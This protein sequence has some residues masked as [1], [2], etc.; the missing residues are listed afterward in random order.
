MLLQDARAAGLTRAKLR[1]G[2]WRRAGPGLYARAGDARRPEVLLD[3]VRGRLP[4]EAAF[5]DRTAGW[6]HELDYEPCN[7]IEV[8]AAPDAKISA[9]SGVT[10]RR[11]LLAPGEIVHV[12]GF[13]VTSPLRTVID[14]AS[15]RPLVEGVI[16]V[17]MALHAELV[18]MDELDAAL[19]ARVGKKGSVQLRQV[20]ALADGKAESPMESRLRVL[21][22]RSGL[23]PPE[24]QVPLFDANGNFVARPDLYYPEHR[25]AIEFD[26][27][28]HRDQLV[29]DNRRQ[30]LMTA[31]GVR[32]LRFTT[33]DVFGRPESVVRQVANEL[34]TPAIRQRIAR[35]EDR[36]D[37]IRRRMGWGELA[38]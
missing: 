10:L 24:S 36:N 2:A 6:L 38:S 5:S 27:G 12:R 26:G 4:A 29:E 11:A 13:P 7:P 14:L 15:R 16:A 9:R 30:N 19:R 20:L 25:L 28:I 22:Q 21:V 18:T 31:L 23:P 3:A 33:A 32:L 37:R 8:V 1:S 17:D 35:M 34:G